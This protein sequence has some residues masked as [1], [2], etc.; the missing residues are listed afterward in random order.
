[1]S[2]V[3]LTGLLTGL[4]GLLVTGVPLYLK[5]VQDRRKAVRESNRILREGNRE[6]RKDAI[7]EMSRVIDILQKERAVDRQ[8]MHDLR[9]AQGVLSN[10]LAVCE[11]NR[12][13]QDK[14]IAAQ[15][16]RIAEWESRR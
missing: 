12:T 10:R 8:E 14:K 15:D 1:M 6:D 9:D 4:G 16:R 3:F 11:A 5:I 7:D 2:D 13:E